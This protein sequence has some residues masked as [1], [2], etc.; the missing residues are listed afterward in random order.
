MAMGPPSALGR[1][2]GGPRTEELALCAGTMGVRLTLITFEGR[3]GHG[4]HGM[5][6]VS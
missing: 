5:G 2:L 3:G 6:L 4:P 1:H